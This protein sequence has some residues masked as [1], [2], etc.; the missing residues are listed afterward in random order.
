MTVYE[1]HAYNPYCDCYRCHKIGE[2]YNPI[3]IDAFISGEMPTNAVKSNV[4][5]I[6]FKTKKPPRIIGRTHV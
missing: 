1:K 4:V 3:D 2:G 5:Y 6:N